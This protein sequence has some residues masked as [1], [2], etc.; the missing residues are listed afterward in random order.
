MIHIGCSRAIR[1]S[2]RFCCAPS[3][4]HRSAGAGP[5][6]QRSLAPLSESHTPL[7]ATRTAPTYSFPHTHQH[8][9]LNS[10]IRTGRCFTFTGWIVN[11]LLRHGCYQRID[12][13]EALNYVAFRLLSP[14]GERGQPRPT[15]FEFDESRP[16][17]PGT[18]PLEG[19]FKTFVVRDIRS[20]CGGK[21]PKFKILNRPQGT[22]TISQRPRRGEPQPG[23]VGADQI[24]AP[25]KPHERE[26]FGDIM[27]LL[28]RNSVPDMPLADLW[29]AMLEGMPL[30]RQRQVF[31][32]GRADTMR[33][34]IKA[35][36]RDYA[37]KSQNHGL[38]RLLDKF[39]DFKGNRPDL[40]SRRQKKAKLPPRPKDP[41]EVQDFLSIIDV[42][43]RAGFRATMALL[44]KKRR[45]WLER[46]PRDPASEEKTR[47]HD[48]LRSMLETGVLA[49]HGPAYVPGPNYQQFRNGHRGELPN[50]SYI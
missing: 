23:L 25:E 43:E 38:L 5:P 26:L 39:A 50:G 8:V 31:G 40:S 7:P 44:G 35:M 45:R 37:M 28:Q 22:L 21:M 36:L 16:Y 9:T 48:V 49:K 12:P 6:A 41:P 42:L 3:R 30:E 4:S 2:S 20:I 19:R 27:A 13:D 17:E 10:A 32:H 14:V 11:S 34:T 47:L 1:S 24:P 33:K 29:Q 15:L 46:K 18:N